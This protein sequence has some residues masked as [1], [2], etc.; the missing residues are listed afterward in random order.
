MKAKI[1]PLAFV[2]GQVPCGF[3][4]ISP[5]LWL[6]GVAKWS[7]AS[8][9]FSP[10]HFSFQIPDPVCQTFPGFDPCGLKWIAHIV[11]SG[12]FY[13]QIFYF[14]ISFLESSEDCLEIGC[15]T[16]ITFII[17]TTITVT[18]TSITNT[19]RTA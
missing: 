2:D 11:F 18:L 8:K 10:V 19:V 9:D 6:G 3:A 16:T 13:V 15:I 4:K 14:C 12:L 7:C 17:V 1:S 5:P